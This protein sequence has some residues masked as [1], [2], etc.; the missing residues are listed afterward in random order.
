MFAENWK[1]CPTAKQLRTYTHVVLA[2]AVTYR[3]GAAGKECSPDCAVRLDSC[4][5]LT[6]DQTA[7]AVPRVVEQMRAQGVHVSFS[8]GGAEMDSCYATCAGRARPV[9]DDLLRIFNHSR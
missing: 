2:F 7:E 4:G 1:M 5:L 8:F 9:A 6:S 3:W